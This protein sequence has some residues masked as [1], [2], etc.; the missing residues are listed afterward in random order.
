MGLKIGSVI[1]S[2]IATYL[3]VVVGRIDGHMCERFD[4]RSHEQ[5]DHDC[6]RNKITL[7][8]IYTNKKRLKFLIQHLLSK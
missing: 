1:S 3:L 8:K 4:D 2:K 6:W 5:N 7:V